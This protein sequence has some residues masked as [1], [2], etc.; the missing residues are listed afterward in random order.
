M[1]THNLFEDSIVGLSTQH[2]KSQVFKLE[3][4]GHK[5]APTGCRG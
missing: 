3:F 5:K 2:L 1:L 4:F